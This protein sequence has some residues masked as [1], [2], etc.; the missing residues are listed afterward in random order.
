M[1]IDRES[2]WEEAGLQHSP[3]RLLWSYCRGGIGRGINLQDFG[4]VVCDLKA[5]KPTV[6]ALCA[7]IEPDRVAD[8]LIDDRNRV[9]I[10]NAGRILRR[11]NPEGLER[12]VVVLHQPRF[13]DEENRPARSGKPEDLTEII[14]QIG[15]R[16]GRLVVQSYLTQEAL[17][18]G[19]AEF[20]ETGT[21]TPEPPKSNSRLSRSKRQTAKATNDEKRPDAARIKVREFLKEMNSKGKLWSEASKVAHLS[22]YFN[23]D[24]IEDLTGC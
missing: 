9:V 11:R 6:A 3:A 16:A 17:L 18:R 13:F 21:A 10:Q 23:K 7:T 19:I 22:R 15:S 2:H 24:E 5:F 20:F 8:A 12:R 14:S 4:I 1:Y